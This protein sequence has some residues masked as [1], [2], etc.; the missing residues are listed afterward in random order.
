MPAFT[1]ASAM[2]GGCKRGP[3]W[4]AAVFAAV[5]GYQVVES[6]VASEIYKQRLQTLSQDYESLRGRFNEV[7]RNEVS[8]MSI[9]SWIGTTVNTPPEHLT[10]YFGV[11][12]SPDLCNPNAP[13]G[14]Q[15]LY[16]DKLT[17]QDVNKP[18]HPIFNRLQWKCGCQ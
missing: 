13:I 11:M 12:I 18:Y 8:A 9:G 4:R 7:V 17:L 3:L 5:F 1:I 2:S 15:N 14:P 10:H 16:R 6:R